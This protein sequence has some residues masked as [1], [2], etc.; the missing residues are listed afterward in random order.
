MEHTKEPWRYGEDNDGWYVACGSEQL[1]YALSEANARRIVACVNACAGIDDPE[2][3][4]NNA[5]FHSHETVS[6]IV[7]QRDE[8]LAAFTVVWISAN[9]EAWDAKTVARFDELLVL[10]VA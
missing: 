8:L 9:R 7:K 5:R 10:V 4:I 6:A 2:A 1:G 3:W